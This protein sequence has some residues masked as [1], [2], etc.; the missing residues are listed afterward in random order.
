MPFSLVTSAQ[1]SLVLTSFMT[2]S[3]ATPHP[4]FGTPCPAFPFSFSPFIGIGCLNGRY[5]GFTVDGTFS[6]YVVSWV[7]HVTPIPDE[8]SSAEAA[9]ILCAVSTLLSHYQCFLRGT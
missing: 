8:L 1:S 3:P 7:T 5:S 4:A 6:Q 9:S 2:S